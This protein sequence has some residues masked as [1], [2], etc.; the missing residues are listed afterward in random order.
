VDHGIR[1][2]ILRGHQ[3]QEARPAATPPPGHRATAVRAGT[4]HQGEDGDPERTDDGEE[5]P[6]RA[7]PPPPRMKGGRQEHPR[8]PCMEEGPAYRRRETP[9]EPLGHEAGPPEQVGGDVSRDPGPGSPARG[10]SDR[11][12]E[13]FVLENG[14]AVVNEPLPTLP[15]SGRSRARQQIPA[16]RTAIQE[17]ATDEQDPEGDERGGRPEDERHHSREVEQEEG[18]EQ[19]SARAELPAE[20]PRLRRGA[21]ACPWRRTVHGPY[22][23]FASTSRR[24]A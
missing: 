2:R 15:G 18:P 8:H 19:P 10:R 11:G 13:H 24:S 22:R 23:T 16:G 20:V 3:P 6:E 21:N 4:P 12:G 5:P 1:R 9:S 7:A 17:E 14:T